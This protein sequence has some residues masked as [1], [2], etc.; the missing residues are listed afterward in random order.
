VKRLIPL[1]LLL[2]TTAFSGNVSAA[3]FDV[4][5]SILPQKYFLQ[6]L[7]GEHVHVLVMVSPGASPATYEPK[8]GQMVALSKAKAYF[9]IGVPFEKTWLPRFMGL[10]KQLPIIRTDEGITKEP[11]WQSGVKGRLRGEKTRTGSDIDGL[12]PHIWTSP[13]LVMLQ[14]RTI[15]DGLSRVDPSH[16]G[17][18][19][20]NYRRFI[21]ELVN[22]DLEIRKSLLP[23]ARGK[24]F[25]VFHPSW[26]YFA[27]A[28]G[29][30]QVAIEKEGK[31]PGPRHLEELIGFARKNKVRAIFIQPQFSRKS[32][33]II[34]RAIG[35][36]VLSADPLAEDWARNLQRVAKALGDTLDQ[37]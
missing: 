9:S 13:S 6:K 22:L 11:L 19:E 15:T 27:H 36:R 31:A 28:Y 20:A 30:R 24:T 1:L 37:P 12:D 33:R 34:A 17:D 7:G 25:M 10:Y 4:F 18:F 5:V 35:A 26:G 23:L 21:H 29:L 2:F 14:A 32:A 16:G 8:P 3:P